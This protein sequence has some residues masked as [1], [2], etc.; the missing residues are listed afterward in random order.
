[1]SLARHI[2]RTSSLLT[3]VPNAVGRLSFFSILGCK[4]PHLRRL[5]GFNRF[6]FHSHNK[7]VVIVAVLV[8]GMTVRGVVSFF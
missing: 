3:D 1:M 8:L 6:C 7:Y 4:N 2:F 5:V